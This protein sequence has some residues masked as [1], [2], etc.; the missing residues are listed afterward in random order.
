MYVY[1]YIYMHMCIY[2][3]IYIYTRADANGK[4][5]EAVGPAPLDGLT[6]LRVGLGVRS[7]P[8]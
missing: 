1:I 4:P 8:A 6:G 2:I 5:A 3:Y 7:A